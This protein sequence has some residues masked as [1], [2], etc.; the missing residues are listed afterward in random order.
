MT[1]SRKAIVIFSIAAIAFISA[2]VLLT[3]VV[4]ANGLPCGCGDLCVNETGWWRAGGTFNASDTPIQAAVDNATAGETICL[5][6]GTYNENVDVNVAHI[7]IRS[8]NGSAN[9]FVNAAYYKDYVFSV[10]AD[11]VNISGFTVQN[12][13]GS[14]K[15]G[16]YLTNVDHCTI[17]ENTASNNFYGIYLYYSSTNNLTGNTASYNDYGIYLYYSS[18]NNLTGNTASNNFYGIYL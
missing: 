2:F 13:P 9:C 1:T 12:A 10:T 8:E 15:A 3:T 17:S 5:Q 6:D 14:G 18:T 4:S 7:T 16:I 11:W